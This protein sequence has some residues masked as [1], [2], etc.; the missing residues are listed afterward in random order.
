VVPL[1]KGKI[2]IKGVRER[3]EMTR[4]WRKMHNEEAHNLYSS[5]YLGDQIKDG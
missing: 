1:L 2:S 5:T 3:E 4:G